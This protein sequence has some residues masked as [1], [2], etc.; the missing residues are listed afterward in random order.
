MNKL[1]GFTAENTYACIDFDGTI[2]VWTIG[3]RGR[4]MSSISFLVT[5]PSIHPEFDTY[6]HLLYEKYRPIETSLA[7]SSDEKDLHMFQWW[8]EVFQLFERFWVW[9]K[10]F[11]EARENIKTLQIREW[12]VEF[13]RELPNKW[14]PVIIFS[15]GIKNIIEKFLEYHWVL[16]PNTFIIANTFSFEGNWNI[17]LPNDNEIIYSANKDSRHFS[18][19]VIRI[20]QWRENIIVMWDN[21]HD[22][23]MASHVLWKHNIFSIWFLNSP[24]DTSR[25]DFLSIYDEV[26]E[27][28][29]STLGKLE[30]ILNFI[31]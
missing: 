1:S 4:P 12:M 19:E 6:G 27:S 30:K 29:D 20:I 25:K 10:V 8:K 17:I 21:Y 31:I 16:T 2:S 28:H 11:D 13:L 9:K 5:Q 15:A 14:I 22:Y 23:D 26:I 18:E 3:E 24:D 7:M